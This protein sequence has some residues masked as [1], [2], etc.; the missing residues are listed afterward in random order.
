MWNT[1]G[2][3]VAH[4]N[5]YLM[6]KGFYKFLIVKDITDEMKPDGPG[7]AEEFHIGPSLRLAA[8]TAWSGQHS[9]PDRVVSETA[10]CRASGRAGLKPNHL[11]LGKGTPKVRGWISQ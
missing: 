10:D 3:D 9:S 5:D 7:S 11:N 8:A 4:R 2:H 6:L 1:L